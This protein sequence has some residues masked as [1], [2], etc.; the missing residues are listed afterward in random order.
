MSAV[1]PL[2]KTTMTSLFRS[3]TLSLM[4]LLC[5]VL[6]HAC[7]AMGGAGDSPRSDSGIPDSG[8]GAGGGP[9]GGGSGGGGSV[10]GGGGGRA[11]GGAGD[12]GGGGGSAGGGPLDEC[13]AGLPGRVGTQ[14]LAT[15][16]SADGRIRVRIA[17]D[18]ADRGG[19]SG[20][21]GWGLVR[22][23]VEL[24]GAVS[25]ITQPSQLSYV[26]SHHNCLDKAGAT[27]G[28][29]TFE[30]E[31]PDD[32]STSLTVR[33]DGTVVHESVVLTDESCSSSTP[34][35]PQTCRSGGPC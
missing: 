20:T 22:L 30:L 21:M 15:K 7:G 23:G 16:K 13:F 34:I 29:M 2:K 9:G 18:T 6:A 33:K 10:G 25:C 8:T 1:H 24:D 32:G 19:T 31:D 14:M 3:V 26:G 11:G 35:G 5:V 4:T 28:A 12:G 17:L 27:A